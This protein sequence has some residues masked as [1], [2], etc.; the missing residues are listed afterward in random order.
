M[1][2]GFAIVGGWDICGHHQ[3]HT[4]VLLAPRIIVAHS[5]DLFYAINM[6]GLRC[7]KIWGLSKVN[8]IISQSVFY[9]R[10]FSKDCSSVFSEIKIFK[11]VFSIK[12]WKKC[13]SKSVW[14]SPFGWGGVD[15]A[16]TYS[17]WSLWPVYCIFWAFMSLFCEKTS[18]FVQDI[19]W[20]FANYV[21]NK[22]LNGRQFCGRSE[23]KLHFSQK[24]RANHHTFIICKKLKT[25][26]WQNCNL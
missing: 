8:F 6:W 22:Y 20:S 10:R 5:R 17:P 11:I 24:A 9:E 1:L 14:A 19:L 21:R 7:G 26:S 25:I 4:S 12:K 16:K 18:N 2:K 23:A 13:V 15:W 3:S